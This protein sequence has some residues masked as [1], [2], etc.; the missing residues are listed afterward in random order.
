MLQNIADSAADQADHQRVAVADL[1]PD[2]PPERCGDYGG[3]PHRREDDSRT[4]RG[5]GSRSP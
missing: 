2:L 4:K 5:V 1:L 3:D